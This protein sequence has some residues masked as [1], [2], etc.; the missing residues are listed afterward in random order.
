ME[1]LTKFGAR[2]MT[3]G[4]MMIKD[5][6]FRIIYVGKINTIIGKIKLEMLRRKIRHAPLSPHPDTTRFLMVSFLS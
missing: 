2:F 4:I 1:S 3:F 6:L 5:K